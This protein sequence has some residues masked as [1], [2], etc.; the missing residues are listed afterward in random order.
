MNGKEIE[1][2]FLDY[3]KNRKEEDVER[4][5]LNEFIE[6]LEDGKKLFDNFLEQ[7][8]LKEAGPE[9]KLNFLKIPEL[10]VISSRLNIQKSNKKNEI[11][12]MIINEDEST[13]YAEVLNFNAY[14]ITEKGQEI[15]DKYLSEVK[16]IQ[17][18]KSEKIIEFVKNNKIYV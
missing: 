2:V 3:I 11:I 15:V 16:K 18:E 12:E 4:I 7:G 10:E 9:E 8:V 17:E 13:G 1:I 5:F 14:I 6:E